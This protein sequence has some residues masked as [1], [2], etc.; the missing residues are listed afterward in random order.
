MLSWGSLSLHCIINEMGSRERANTLEVT[1]RNE[2]GEKG[3][4][5]VLTVIFVFHISL[6]VQDIFCIYGVDVAPAPQR[7]G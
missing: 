3:R 7:R 1:V 6:L 5:N 4:K 2:N